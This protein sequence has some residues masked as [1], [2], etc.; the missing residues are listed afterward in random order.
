MAYNSA[1]LVPLQT[2]YLE[3]TQTVWLYSTV[4]S[5]ATVKGANYFSDA[6]ARGLKKGDIVLTLFP[7][8]PAAA[9]LQVAAN[10]TAAGASV[11]A[12]VVVT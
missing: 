8:T 12:T 3:N 10:P 7:A 4:D 2:G 11:G 6:L 1:T 5:E 9:I